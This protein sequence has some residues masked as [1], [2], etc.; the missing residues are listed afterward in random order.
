MAK[1]GR[2]RGNGHTGRATDGGYPRGLNTLATVV[3][4]VAVMAV[5]ILW[6]VALWPKK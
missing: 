3:V 6:L 2:G 5:I 4:D 1:P